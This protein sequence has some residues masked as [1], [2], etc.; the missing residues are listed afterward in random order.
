MI[1]IMPIDVL[2]WVTLGFVSLLGILISI[3]MIW[4]EEE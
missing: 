1:E 2:G 3:L 4:E